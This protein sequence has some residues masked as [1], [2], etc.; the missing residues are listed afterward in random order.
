M[1][2][3]ARNRQSPS[4]GL[5]VPLWG[6]GALLA[7]VLGVAAATSVTAVAGLLAVLAAAAV[8]V[9][10]FTE[11]RWALI[12]LLF[13]LYSYAGWVLS[14]AV[15]APEPSQA[16][17]LLIATALAWRHLTRAEKLSV[18]G[19]L[20]IFIVLWLT[21]AASAAFATDPDA[22]LLKIR[23]LSGYG[24][25]VVTLVA[26]LDRPVW[27]RRAVW[28][29]V[30][31][32][33][34]L[35]SISLLQAAT[36]AYD[37]DFAGF[38]LARPEGEGVF[39]VSGP[40]DP[41]VFGQV[42]VATSMLALYLALSARDR[43]GRALALS[44]FTVCIAA[45]GLTGSRGA[46][47]AAAAAFCLLLLFAPI[48]RGVVAA[49]VALVVTAG[50]VFL[51]SGIQARVGVPV[52]SA[53]SEQV[54]AVEKGSDSAIRGRKSE[55]IAALQMFRDHPLF[56][57]GPGNYPRHYLAYSQEIG[58][59]KRLENREPHN[60]Y[61]GTLA[62]T[63][64]VGASAFFAVLWLAL[65]GAWRGRR[66]LRGRDALLA[67]GIFVA[68]ASFLVAGLFL[69]ST[70]PRYTWILIGFGFVAG[71]LA[72]NQARARELATRHARRGPHRTAAASTVPA[73]P[74][75]V[76]GPAVAE[77]QPVTWTPRPRGRRRG[78]P[79]LFTAATM[80]AVATCVAIGL[81]VGAGNDKTPA[82]TAPPAEPAGEPVG[83]T[84]H[85]EPII[86]SG[87]ANSGKEYT[88][89][90]FDPGGNP[91]GCTRAQ[92]I[93]LSALNGVGDTAIGEWSCTTNP[94]GSTIATCTTVR[95]Q[96]IQA[97]G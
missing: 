91:I 89:T 19:E 77:P 67:E 94:A 63:G 21:F 69:H 80:A 30:V 32:G 18:P 12:V 76:E 26:L 90:S 81:M 53:P 4:A 25:L 46:L 2:A 64:I 78:R 47:V 33:G 52:G 96:K 41:N 75:A 83:R 16:L 38:A 49:T 8:V 44:M 92:S 87:P 60:L 93:L 58:L 43:A 42:L 29:L 10:A 34:A 5:A 1:E 97:G 39:R 35:A 15:G 13:V 24:L 95:G 7:V 79:A 11:T 54:T 86:G 48:P 37:S 85:C 88:L 40:L 55:N 6:G 22:S 50:L 74:V 66:W 70:Y 20:T 71:Q 68:L 56:G 84:A 57:V 51:P 59:D 62:E 3:L 28:T 14:N 73:E 9:A 72:H 17:V 61:L 27:L 36:G 65:R 45:T 31:A 82:E 23:D